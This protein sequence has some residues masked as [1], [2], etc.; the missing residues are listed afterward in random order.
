VERRLVLREGMWAGRKEQRER[1]IAD[2]LGLEMRYLTLGHPLLRLDLV[3]LLR[4]GAGEDYEMRDFRVEREE[5]E[6]VEEEREEEIIE[7]FCEVDGEE[8]EGP[9]EEW[10]TKKR[11]RDEDDEEGGTSGGG[12]GSGGALGVGPLSITCR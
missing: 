4:Q 6:V 9:G 3:E 7:E 2:L 5:E 12:V 1:E 10:V 8:A 11:G